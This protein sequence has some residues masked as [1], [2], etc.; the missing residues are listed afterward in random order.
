MRAA[1]AAAIRWRAAVAA[2]LFAL[3]CA[4]HVSAHDQ[5]YSW[6]D[7]RLA[8]DGLEGRVTA[9]IVDLAHE[10]GIATPDSLLEPAFAARHAAALEAMLAPRLVL[11]ADGD[12]LRP[13]W[14]GHEPVAAR[15][16][17]AFTWR[18]AWARAPGVLTVAGPL[19]PYDPQHETYLNV[20]ESGALRHQDLLDHERT[21]Y[22]HY[23]GSRQGLLAVFRTFLLAGIHHIFIGPDHILFI[24]GLLLPGGRPLQL[25]KIVTGFTLAHSVTLAL[26]TLGIVNPPARLVEPTIALSIVA[27]GIGNLR[28]RPGAADSRAWV[29]LGFGFVHGFGFASVLRDFG[30]PREALGASLFAFNLGVEVGQACIVAVVAPLLALT[31]SR[32]PAQ[33]PRV[34]AVGSVIVTL[35]GAYWFVERVFFAPR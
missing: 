9:H 18:T 26:A 7:L 19:F 4:A 22:D 24:I 2:A 3:L 20:Y 28:V 23:T 21:R 31:R 30:L 13:A 10:A 29:A 5:P 27:V 25:L 32:A 34:V 35:A 16:A 15:K 6:L 17:L 14:I 12:T 33:A 1:G 8:G 11:I